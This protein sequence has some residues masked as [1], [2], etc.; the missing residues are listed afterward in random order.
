MASV[1]DALSINEMLLSDILGMVFEEYARLEWR[2]PVISGQVCRS[3]RQVVLRRP[4]A[5]SHIKIFS[6]RPSY[7]PSLRLWLSR[8]GSTPLHLSILVGDPY[9]PLVSMLYDI[10]SKYNDRIETLKIPWAPHSFFGGRAFPMLQ[11]LDIGRWYSQ[12]SSGTWGPMPKLHTLRIG[13]TDSS[14]APLDGLPPLT[15]LAVCSTHCSSLV[16]KSFNTLTTLMLQA[17]SFLK[18]IPKSITFPSLTYLSLYAVGNLKPRIVA[19]ALVTYHE[20][21]CTIRESLSTSL[22]SVIEYGLYYR[23]DYTPLPYRP[24]PVELHSFFPH[25][26]RLSIRAPVSYL[27]S[28]LET[29]ANEPA[30]LPDLH[31][32]AVGSISQYTPV[33]E[34]E[35]REMRAHVLARNLANKK[36]VTLYLEK[37][38]SFHIP[39]FF[40]V[41]RYHLSRR[42]LI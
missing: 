40:G 12:D 42:E 6:I 27:P 18:D 30:S 22:P 11:D 34:K 36:K 14:F 13:R 20:G 25:I 23:P 9:N 38:G 33:G 1:S 17:I 31:K 15:V 28:I 21:G 29:L 7:I 37:E 24:D 8:S 26:S 19:P 35:F 4:R 10:L 2:A 41:V 16:H 5:W 32:I 3:W 39:L